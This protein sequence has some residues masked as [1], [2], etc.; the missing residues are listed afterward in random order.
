MG[1]AKKSSRQLH[2][3]RPNRREWYLPF[4]IFLGRNNGDDVSLKN[5]PNRFLQVGI[6][7]RAFR[8]MVHR[9]S[10]S[11]YPQQFGGL[12]KAPSHWSGCWFCCKIVFSQYNCPRINQSDCPYSWLKRSRET[13]TKL[14][15]NRALIVR[16]NRWTNF[17]WSSLSWTPDTLGTSVAQLENKFSRTL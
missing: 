12:V 14:I 10:E 15:L 9:N 8:K 3:L 17:V 16:Y 13:L 7:L 1:V 2:S 6:P 11:K 5:Q 4:L